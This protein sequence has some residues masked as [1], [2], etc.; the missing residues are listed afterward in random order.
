MLCPSS[1]VLPCDVKKVKPEPEEFED[2]EFK[3]DEK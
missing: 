2:E 1:D 3:E